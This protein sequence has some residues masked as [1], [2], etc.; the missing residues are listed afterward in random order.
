MS[1]QSPPKIGDVQRFVAHF[2]DAEHEEASH[3]YDQLIELR[4]KLS[5]RMIFGALALNGASVFGLMSVWEKLLKLGFY[6][7]ELAGLSATL[8]A[9]VA[10]AGFSAVFQQVNIVRN[11][12]RQ[13]ARMAHLRRMKAL[14]AT[15]YT[16][17]NAQILSEHIDQLPDHPPRD[18]KESI[19]A[20]A[21]R[22]LSGGL[23]L[24]AMGYL[25]AKASGIV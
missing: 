22:G 15:D 9:G 23:W 4:D 1:D 10:S 2:N 20:F 14:M 25:L 16:E 21:L 7:H 12:A 24:G 18:F 19:A 3:R 8:V 13:Y 11:A 17:S 5:E 6:P